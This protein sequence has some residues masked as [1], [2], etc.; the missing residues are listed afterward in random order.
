MDWLLEH[1]QFVA[2]ALLI[3]G[4]M[5]RK[6]LEAK[7]EEQEARRRMEQPGPP[8][9]A[10][11]PFEPAEPWEAYEPFEPT[12]PPIPQPPARSTPPPVPAFESQQA[13]ILQR[14]TEIEEQLRR[15]REGRS[16]KQARQAKPARIA[17][18]AATTA[19]PTTTGATSIRSTLRNRGSARRAIVLREVLGQ[20]VGLR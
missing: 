1:F 18:P 2:I 17:K 20:P 7:A 16:A 15:I 12:P 19:A 6:F 8:E 9:E 11:E 13:A 10:F 4:S 14:Q 5:I 3:A